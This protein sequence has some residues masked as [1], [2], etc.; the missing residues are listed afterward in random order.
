MVMIRKLLSSPNPIINGYF[1]FLL[2]FFPLL[3]CY[4][5]WTSISQNTSNSIEKW[6][7]EKQK[8]ENYRRGE[9]NLGSFLL[10]KFKQVNTNHNHKLLVD[11]DTLKFSSF[12]S[13]QLMLSLVRIVTFHKWLLWP[14][15]DKFL[16]QEQ[17]YS[18]RNYL[19][20]EGKIFLMQYQGHTTQDKI[21]SKMT[22]I[23]S[24]FSLL[25]HISHIL[26][27]EY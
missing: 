12:P 14:Q 22:Y 5:Y 9:G 26:E 11:I 21:Q 13:C 10:S 1:N 19:I 3:L 24:V 6:L 27:K 17:L 18:N 7:Y 15:K 2:L 8:L 25:K 4:E 16:N 20:L 23:S